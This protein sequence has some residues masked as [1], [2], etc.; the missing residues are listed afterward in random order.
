MR[1]S[2]PR[3]TPILALRRGARSGFPRVE[4][5]GG[6]KLRPRSN[7]HSHFPRCPPPRAALCDSEGRPSWKTAIQTRKSAAIR[8]SRYQDFRLQPSVSSPTSVLQ[9]SAFSH[10]AFPLVHNPSS[11]L[12]PSAFSILPFPFP[13]RPSTT[14]RPASRIGLPISKEIG[15]HD[16]DR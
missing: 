5:Y 2:P 9:R 16:A 8:F 11:I 7:Q 3:A 12:P 1:Q 6:H 14:S 13:P 15:G 10:S 4:R